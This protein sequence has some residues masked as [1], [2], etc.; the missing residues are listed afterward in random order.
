MIMEHVKD[1]HLGQEY[2]P[3]EP[4]TTDQGLANIDPGE[5][6]KFTQRARMKAFNELTD[7]G[8]NITKHLGDTMQLLRDLDGAA[9]TTRKL[10]IEEK[11]VDDG[12]QIQAT[13]K[14]V[15]QLLGRDPFLVEH[16]PGEEIG[17]AHV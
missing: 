10:N 3:I 1:E 2:L 15:R 12:R 16:V 13:A 11:V 17:R 9:L 5:V 4:P 6:V 8:S 14:A 7:N